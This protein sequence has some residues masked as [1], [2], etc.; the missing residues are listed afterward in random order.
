MNTLLNMTLRDVLR[1]IG[2]GLFVGA[3]FLMPAWAAL[4]GATP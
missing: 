3:V 1:A 2:G 4:L